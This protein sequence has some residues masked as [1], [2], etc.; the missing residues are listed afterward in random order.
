MSAEKKTRRLPNAGP[1]LNMLPFFLRSLFFAF[2]SYESWRSLPYTKNGTHMIFIS[3]QY[4]PLLSFSCENGLCFELKV[5]AKNNNIG[6]QT[7]EE[8][9]STFCF[10][11]E[12]CFE[13]RQKV[14]RFSSNCDTSGKITHLQEE[15]KTFYF[16]QVFKNMAKIFISFLH[17]II[18]LHRQKSNILRARAVVKSNDSINCHSLL[19]ALKSLL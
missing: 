15:G 9:V 6:K 7:W 19:Q 18:S 12:V 8:E 11:N 3:W 2:W 14:S 10:E 13:K 1:Y 5:K 17:T 4:F 16:E